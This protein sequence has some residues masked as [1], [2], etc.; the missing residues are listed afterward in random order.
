MSECDWG[1]TNTCPRWLKTARIPLHFGHSKPEV[2]GWCYDV[3]WVWKG[4]V[5]PLDAL[6]QY[7]DRVV[8]WHLRQS[9]NGV[10]WEQLD[11][12]DIDYASVAQYAT[13]HGLARRFSVELALE[14]GTKITRSVIE[15]HRLSREFVRRVFGA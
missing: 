5:L 1:F 3:H 7:G 14:P 9:R 4:G 13:E 2:V 12:G 6:R 11:T 15:N 8:T 10:W